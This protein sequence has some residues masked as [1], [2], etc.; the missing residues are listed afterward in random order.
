MAAL[1]AAAAATASANKPQAPAHPLQATS[2]GTGFAIA[3]PGYV[4]RFPRDAGA[5]AA[6]ADEWWYFTGNLRTASGHR[7]GF[8]LTFFRIS[9]R[10]RAALNDDLFFAHFA[11][12]DITGRHFYFHA[13]ARR[14]AW[15][16]AGVRGS[17]PLLW[18]VN[19]QA[20]FARNGPRALR[21][22]WGQFGLRLHLQ[23]GRRMFNGPN[24]FSQKGPIPGE[25]SE[26]YSIPRS[27]AVGSV[28]VHG[29]QY[30]VRGLVWMDHEFASDQ[31]APEQIG[32]DWIG[33][34]LQPPAGAAAEA[35]RDLMLFQL[36]DRHGG[37]DPFSAGTLRTLDGDRRLGA[38]QFAM[39]PGRVWRSPDSG[40]RYP[41][42]WRVRVPASGLRLTVTAA[43]D[44][45]ELRAR[46]PVAVDY[47]EGAV[48]VRGVWRG[49]PIH[50]RGY[51]EMTGYSHPFAAFHH[52]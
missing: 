8:E 11:V 47:W 33:L 17:P 42:V 28:T 46:V 27:A 29:R 44:N 3:R 43:L 9:P 21:A 6:F 24:G 1:C 2:P 15:G 14:G 40:G 36:R 35:P 4:W 30:A 49:Q 45:Q 32:W 41:V 50:G 37:R 39:I 12:T 13:R 38:A 51:L 10:P 31:L 26:Y 20:R 18:N 25:A 19:W 7:F 48:R 5:H 16:Q 34:Q 52:R 23:P 22:R